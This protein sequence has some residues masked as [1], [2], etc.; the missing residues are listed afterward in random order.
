LV[1]APAL[2]S[3]AMLGAVAALR[4]ALGEV[5][6][7]VGLVLLVGAGALTYLAIMLLIGRRTMT[8]F[9]DVLRAGRKQRVPG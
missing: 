2:A 4:P 8:R 1:S 3:L 6:A 9:F 7:P 5:P